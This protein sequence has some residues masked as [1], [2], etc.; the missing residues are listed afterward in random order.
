[1]LQKPTAG[2]V[3]GA[4]V[5]PCRGITTDHLLQRLMTC[6]STY[7]MLSGKYMHRQA[8]AMNWTCTQQGIFFTGNVIDVTVK[9]CTAYFCTAT[10][11]VSVLS[12]SATAM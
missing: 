6:C 7:D 10:D 8:R 2:R 11:V 12:V 1:M 5:Q 3:Q 9:N 4:A